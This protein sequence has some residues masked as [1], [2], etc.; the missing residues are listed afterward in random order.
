MRKVFGFLLLGGGVVAGWQFM[1]PGV[2]LPKLGSLSAPS[3]EAVLAGRSAGN[4]G[5]TA[6][7]SGTDAKVS[8]GAAAISQPVST[9]ASA[10]P[11]S[12]SR[13]PRTFS[14]SSPLFAQ[15]GQDPTAKQPA[16]GAARDAGKVVV[17]AAATTPVTV[18][19]EQPNIVTTVVA[20]PTATRGAVAGEE[21]QRALVRDIQKELKRVGCYT[22]E[23]NGQWTQSTSRAMA[24]Y[25]GSSNASLPVDKPDVAFLAMLKVEKAETGCSPSCG[26]GQV[27]A[28]SGICVPR[29]ILAS[30]GKVDGAA[31]AERTAAAQPLPGAMAI[32]GPK[33]EAGQDE[34]GISPS[35]ANPPPS[36]QPPAVKA[37]PP[38]ARKLPPAATAPA[39]KEPRVTRQASR[40]GT[41]AVRDIFEHPLGR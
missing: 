16:A 14:P 32:G 2:D 22:G 7:A 33:V 27:S 25:V 19:V 6:V 31:P 24:T 11:S 20:A 34:T 41:R 10:E 40:E 18:T 1:H 3:L 26:K 12:A 9:V 17:T 39:K 5:A 30:R 15:A 8:P 38:V 4:G 13:A 23:A 29:P 37:P 35:V 21:A 36:E 28:G